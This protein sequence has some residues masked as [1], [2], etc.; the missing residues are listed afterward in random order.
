MISTSFRNPEIPYS[1]TTRQTGTW[2][3]GGQKQGPDTLFNDVELLFQAV[4][5]K[6]APAA[7]I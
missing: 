4:A 5:L 3:L 7:F 6:E 1:D 2:G